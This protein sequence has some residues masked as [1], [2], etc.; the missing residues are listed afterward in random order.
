MEILIDDIYIWND[1]NEFEIDASVK[2]NNND[3]LLKKMIII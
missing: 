2:Q 1:N 3:D